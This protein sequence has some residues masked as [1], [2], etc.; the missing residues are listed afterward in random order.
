MRQPY[1]LRGKTA[2]ECR[3]AHTASGAYSLTPA[4]YAG[5]NGASAAVVAQLARED[6]EFARECRDYDD[7]EAEKE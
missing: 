3:A 5:E 6:A 2:A 1:Y 4:Q 7:A